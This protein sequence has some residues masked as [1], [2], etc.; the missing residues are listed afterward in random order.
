MSPV[1]LMGEAI[2]PGK[3]VGTRFKK[4]VSH[5]RS[6]GEELAAAIATSSQDIVVI[7]DEKVR[8]ATDSTERGKTAEVLKAAG[9]NAILLVTTSLENATAQITGE[10]GDKIKAQ[11]QKTIR[12]NGRDV[13]V[14]VDKT[15]RN[16]VVITGVAK[17]ARSKG[18]PHAEALLRL[19]SLGLAKILQEFPDADLEGVRNMENEVEELD[20]EVLSEKA[21]KPARDQAESAGKAGRGEPPKM[22]EVPANQ[23]PYEKLR[24]DNQCIVM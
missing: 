19:A 18:I 16:P 15:L 24:R 2:I 4:G 6:A 5:L 23:D 1:W 14:L 10:H 22:Q 13:V 17:F 8:S 11:I 9:N 20:A 3:K 21:G 12:T 7:V